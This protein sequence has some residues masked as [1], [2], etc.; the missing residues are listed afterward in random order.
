MEPLKTNVNIGTKIK[1]SCGDCG[2]PTYHEV[3]VDAVLSGA[4]SGGFSE[5]CWA[6]EY[7]VVRCLGCGNIS[8]RKASSNDVESFVQI[9]D[10]EWDYRPSEEIYPN[11][12]SGRSKVRDVSMLPRKVAIIY[13]ETISALNNNQN[14]LCGIGIRAILETV[15]KDKKAKGND[16]YAKIE[17]LVS[18]GVMTAEGASVLHKL[19]VLGNIA[20]HDVKPHK[21]EELILAFDVIDHLLLGVYILRRHARRTFKSKAKRRRSP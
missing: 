21:P 2:F 9:S 16:L 1:C 6:D 20:A 19:R 17:S 12:H 3:I 8:F 13:D 4:S 5:V 14:V 18:L 11:P 15:C 7:Q 10:D